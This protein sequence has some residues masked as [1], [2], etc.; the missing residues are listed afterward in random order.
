MKKTGLS[1]YLADPYVAR[2]R[3]TNEN[4]N[5]LLRYYFSKGTDLSAVS[6]KD[7]ALIVKKLNNRR[8]K[9]LN[10]RTPHEVYRQALRGA[11]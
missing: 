10:Y 3:G 4:A 11:L 9:C 7:V 8:K 1:V 6:E 2:Q 5:R